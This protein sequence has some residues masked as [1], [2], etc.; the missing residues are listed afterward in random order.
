M[1]N[2]FDKLDRPP[3]QAAVVFATAFVIMGIGWILTATEIFSLEPLFAWSIG[4]AFML[5]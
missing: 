2:L 3:M 5:F 1:T 4:A